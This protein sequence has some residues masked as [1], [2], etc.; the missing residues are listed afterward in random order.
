MKIQHPINRWLTGRKQT[1]FTFMENEREEKEII[2]KNTY[3]AYFI[4][5]V[6]LGLV[7]LLVI[8][9]SDFCSTYFTTKL[10]LDEADAFSFLEKSHFG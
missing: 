3:F 4:R 10:S 2:V 5:C 7:Y 1:D 6:L 9:S 8:L